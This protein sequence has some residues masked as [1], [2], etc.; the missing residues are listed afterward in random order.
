MMEYAVRMK[1]ITQR[2]PMVLANDRVDFDVCRAEIHALV[3]ENGA[4]KSTL[5]N[6]LYGLYVPT[7][8]EIE[9]F[10]KTVHMN[11]ALDAISNGIGMVHQHFML[12]PRFT[13]A[14][15]IVLG[16][17]T[18]HS[19]FFF[20]FEKAVRQ[21][22]AVCKEFSL[23]IDVRAKVSDISLGMRQRVEIVKTL[24]R[25][26][27]II[28]LD[29][30]TAVL[31][32]QEIDELGEILKKLKNKGKTVIIITHKL[33]EVK[34]F[35][36]RITVLRNGRKVGTVVTDEVTTQGITRMMV[37]KDVVFGGKK[38]QTNH[39]D[40]ILEL[41]DITC[42]E[43]KNILLDGISISL[44][45]GEILGI[46]GIDGS[47]Q[48]ELA[49]SICGVRK[50]E[51]GVICY[52]GQDITQKTVYERKKEGIAFIP[53]D[54]HRDGLVLSLSVENN[55]LLGQQRKSEYHSKGRT[56]NRKAVKNKALEQIRRFDIRTSS[57][58]QTVS[59]LSGGNQQKIVVAREVDSNP[60]LIVADQP[61]RGIDVAA[62]E[63]IHNVLAEKRNNGCGIVLVSLELDELLLLSDRIAVMNHG[64]IAGIVDPS[65]TTR[66]E[67][68]LLMLGGHKGGGSD[69]VQKT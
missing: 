39:D 31:T 29:E 32:P 12:I 33:E 26:A 55:L 14:E 47:G 23:Q 15:N 17:E 37:G 7:E 60:I 19:L 41:R 21:V 69:S 46:S 5:M 48:T 52:N 13:V 44:H 11:N 25:G 68:G 51:H 27:D 58:T 10:G 36:D 22:E 64:K 40:I 49:E 24:Y 56:L 61:T 16:M 2:F 28:I 8:G 45:R 57:E 9:I 54:R 30:P 67:I 20:D 6:I 53:Q 63:F 38:R 50:I 43:G 3:G 35:S 62:I 42:R 1:G 34:N 18:R 4:G 65:T 59:T 66:E